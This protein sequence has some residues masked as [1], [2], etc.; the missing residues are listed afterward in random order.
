MTSILK[1]L[2]AA[3]A[4]PAVDAREIAWLTF[5]A[6]PEIEA[7]VK[8]SPEQSAEIQRLQRALAFWLPGVP[9]NDPEISDRAGDDAYLLCGY[10]GE[11]EPTAQQ[12]GWIKLRK[13][14]EALARENELLK[15]ALKC[16]QVSGMC[17]Q[18]EVLQGSP[19][20]K[21]HCTANN[22]SFVYHE[23]RCA[24]AKERGE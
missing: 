14:M 18:A 5:N 21:E 12:L 22:C 9:D 10:E 23:Q 4:S 2:E 11:Q 6:I 16:Q 13:E 17:V 7:L 15:L 1:L 20:H 24:I 3:R 8:R 19:V